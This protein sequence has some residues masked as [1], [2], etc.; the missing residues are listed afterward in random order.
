MAEPYAPGA[1]RV[2][3]AL[4]VALVALGAIAPIAT[5]LLRAAADEW[6]S[7]SILPQRYGTRGVGAAFADA[8][9][10]V[11]AVTNSLVVALATTAIALLLAWPAARVIGERRLRR[12]GVIWVLLGLPLLVPPYATGSGLT[13]WFIRLGLA[14]TLTGLV[15]AHLVPVLPYVVLILAGGFRPEVRDLEEAAAV[16]GAG[17]VRRLALVTLPALAP[18]VA[19]AALLGFLVSWSQYGLSLAV[20]GGTPMLPLELVP[21]VA[22]DPQVAAALALVFLTPAV[23]AVALAL[24]LVTRA[25][26]GPRP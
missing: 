11:E 23:V 26:S 4:L 6:R 2:G 13:E 3:P 7:P 24:A 10:V 5:L 21:F 19:V 16:H 9:G 12:P 14:D 1:R 17:R 18:V 20:G 8:P 25:A 22:A 15:V